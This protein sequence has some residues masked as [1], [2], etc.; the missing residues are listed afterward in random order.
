MLR[1]PFHAGA[2]DAEFQVRIGLE[3]RLDPPAA[4]E[5]RG[6]ATGEL[7]QDRVG[8]PCRDLVRAHHAPIGGDALGP[9]GAGGEE[10]CERAVA[11]PDVQEFVG[12]DGQEPVGV[13]QGAVF[14]GQ[15][16]GMGLGFL[17]RRHRVRAVSAE[18]HGV[19][20][21]EHRVGAVAAVVGIDPD[22]IEADQPV[23]GEPFQKAGAFVLH[24]GE[25]RGLGH[26]SQA[27]GRGG[28]VRKSPPAA[29][30][31]VASASV[32]WWRRS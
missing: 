28:A 6:R 20:P 5:I 31:A 14:L 22:G 15:R 7:R 3:E 29:S 23:I 10:G 24:H 25:D 8:G 21:V 9:R 32:R 1:G 2:V 16:Q 17:A 12:V 27:S 18:A 30:S 13:E 11:C 4:P 19:Q 26:R